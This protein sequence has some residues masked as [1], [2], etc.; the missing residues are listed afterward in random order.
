M[1][2]EKE[3]KRKHGKNAMAGNGISEKRRNPDS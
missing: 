1:D 3:A 2:I